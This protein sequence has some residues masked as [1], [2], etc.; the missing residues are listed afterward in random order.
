MVSSTGLG[1]ATSYCFDWV[2]VLTKVAKKSHV[3]ERAI[4]TVIAATELVQ[5]FVVVVRCW[6][7]TWIS[8]LGN[9]LA[10]HLT[11]ISYSASY[12]LGRCTSRKVRS[13]VKSPYPL[14][15]F[16]RY[17]NFHM[18]TACIIELSRFFLLSPQPCILFSSVSSDV[19]V[20]A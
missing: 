12:F 18:Q 15:N 16:I 9:T 6:L 19:K 7:Y 14:P 2:S 13:H 17:S 4:Q 20:S 8:C 3:D 10:S 5:Y 1:N 11:W